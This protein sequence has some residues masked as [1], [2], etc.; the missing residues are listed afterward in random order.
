MHNC[1]NVKNY[2]FN[3]KKPQ[4]RPRCSTI[5]LHFCLEE[6]IAASFPRR[7]DDLCFIVHCLKYHPQCIQFVARSNRKSIR[8]DQN[9]QNK[10]LLHMS[11]YVDRTS[12][13]RQNKQ[14][15]NRKHCY[16]WGNVLLLNRSNGF[17]LALQTME[18]LK[19]F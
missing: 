1:K 10:A 14:S 4:W 7:A 11:V 2:V 3:I 6:T 17:Q 8:W 12:Y 13:Y 5:V 18:R 19:N 16:Q 9:K 15:L